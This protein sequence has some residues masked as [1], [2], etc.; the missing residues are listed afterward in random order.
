MSRGLLLDGLHALR[1]LRPGA[2]RVQSP[3]AVPARRPPR[4]LAALGVALGV[5]LGM[6]ALLAAS[7]CSTTHSATTQPEARDQRP[8]TPDE[9]D[10][11][12][13]ARV[14]LELASAYFSRGQSETALDELKQAIAAD[15]NVAGAYNLRGLIY[16]SLGDDAGAQESFRRALQ[17]DP[18]DADTLQNFGWYLCQ[19]KRYPEAD[20]MFNQALAVPRDRDAPRTLLTQGVCQARAGQPGIAERTLMR[21][22]EL[23]PANPATRSTWP[24]CCTAWVN[25]SAR[26]S[27]SAASTRW[28]NWP[29]RRRCGWHCASRTASAT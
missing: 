23:D 21:S 11:G 24:R 1:R 2:A 29:A 26:A 28:P 12:R 14:R 22:Y 5:T 10:N 7:G 27:R 20:A 15:P 6:A 13:R 8:A 4:P 16:A 17:I 3:P 19:Q 25:T 9:P 18:R